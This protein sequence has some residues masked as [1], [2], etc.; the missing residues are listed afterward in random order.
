MLLIIYHGMLLINT[1]LIIKKKVEYNNSRHRYNNNSQIQRSRRYKS[2]RFRNLG[3]NNFCLH[4]RV[5]HHFIILQRSS[6][7]IVRDFYNR[8]RPHSIQELKSADISGTSDCDTNYFRIL[9]IRERVFSLSFLEIYRKNCFAKIGLP[10][11]KAGTSKHHKITYSSPFTVSRAMVS[12]IVSGCNLR[13]TSGSRGL[14]RENT[15]EICG[16]ESQAREKFLFQ[17]LRN[18]VFP[19]DFLLLMLS[20]HQPD[21]ALSFYV[22]SSLPF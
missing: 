17:R 6:F 12:Q 20:H 22:S 19:V 5:K 13:G 11:I 9:S 2:S 14:P 8:E 3:I 1:F 10:I 7:T 16:A 4:F 21:D 18:R 15:L